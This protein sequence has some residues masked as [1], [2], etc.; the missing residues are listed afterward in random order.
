MLDGSILYT[1]DFNDNGSATPAA[2]TGRDSATIA[3]IGL[4]SLR[5][6]VRLRRDVSDPTNYV[7]SSLHS[8]PMTLSSALLQTSCFKND[9]FL[10]LPYVTNFKEEFI[11]IIDKFKEEISCAKRSKTREVDAE[12]NKFG[13][14]LTRVGVV[15]PLWSYKLSDMLKDKPLS[16][17]D[18]GDRSSS[19]YNYRKILAIAIGEV[20]LPLETIKGFSKKKC[21]NLKIIPLTPC[22][23]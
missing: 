1:I 11:N 6:V 4:W 2:L 9:S 20:A 23:I 14:R 3:F 22:D 5:N 18:A 10:N 8:S 15:E 17:G 7:A 16:G 21:Y 19:P 12:Y 13:K